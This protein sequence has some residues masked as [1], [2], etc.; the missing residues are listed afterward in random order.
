MYRRSKELYKLSKQVIPG[1]V[2]SPVR[3]FKSVSMDP[4]YISHGKGSKI[5]DIDGNEYIDY[6]GSWGPLIL[7]HADE[8]IIH[9]LNEYT[10][11][12]T[13]FGANTEIEVRFAELITGIYPSMDKIRMVNSG[14]EATMSAVRLARGY[15]SRNKIIKFEGCYHGHGD[16]FL[17]KAGSGVLTLGIP[18]TPGVTPGTAGNTLVASSVPLCPLW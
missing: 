13:S 5:T 8:R 18:G 9:K 3:A 11:R 6:V 4:V 7:G 1:G 10:A 17:I 12:G 14:T 16:S 2:N 15:T